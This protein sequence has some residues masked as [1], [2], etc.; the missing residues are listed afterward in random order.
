MLLS[1]RGAVHCSV[2]TIVNGW[3]NWVG[4]VYEWCVVLILC[5]IYVKAS[6]LLVLISGYILCVLF[7]VSYGCDH[8][9]Y[10]SI[11]LYMRP[12]TLSSQ[13]YT[14]LS[15]CSLIASL[16]LWCLERLHAGHVAPYVDTNNDSVLIRHGAIDLRSQKFFQR[17]SLA[18][19]YVCYLTVV[20]FNSDFILQFFVFPF[21][22]FLQITLSCCE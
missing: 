17:L 10:A 3:N 20:Q 2:E 9:I 13:V 19:K 7:L 11:P 6:R 1:G 5:F 14:S 4:L 21:V 12:F 16:F 15:H 18:C 22:T 8:G